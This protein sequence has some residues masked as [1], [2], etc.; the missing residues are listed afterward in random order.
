MALTKCTEC[1]ERISDRAFACPH[2]G[3]PT[4]RGGPFGY[5]YR[6][7]TTVLGMPLVHM[8]SGIDPA[9][10]RKRVAR[11]FIAIGDVAVGV[12]AVGGVAV[13]G[14]AFGGLAL[15][16]VALGGV[17]IGVLLGL[18]GGAVGYI[19]FGGMALGYYAYGGAALGA[20]ALGGTAQDPEAAAFLDRLLP[21]AS[22]LFRSGR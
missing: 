5:D 1:G 21:G 12:I 3:A 18:G 19:A 10:G 4:G 7:E 22:Q 11:G 17:A 6:S 2:C 14:L 8:T 13:G 16:V 15:G 9:T 20:H